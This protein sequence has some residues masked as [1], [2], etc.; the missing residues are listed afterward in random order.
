MTPRLWFRPEAAQKARDAARWYD[1]RS[2][3]LGLEFAR[4]LDV[5]TEAIARLPEAFPVVLSIV[6]CRRDPHRWPTGA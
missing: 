3:G 5:V 6:H 1:D 2:P 4:P